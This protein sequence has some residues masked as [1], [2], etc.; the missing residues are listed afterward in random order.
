MAHEVHQILRESQ[1]I[2]LEAHSDHH[3]VGVAKKHNNNDFAST[4]AA[5]LSLPHTI[6]S[7]LLTLLQGSAPSYRSQITQGGRSTLQRVLVSSLVRGVLS[8]DPHATN[9][10]TPFGRDADR[11]SQLLGSSM[12]LSKNTE[13]A[14]SSLL[15]KKGADGGGM[16]RNAEESVAGAKMERG[17]PFMRFEC[18]L[19]IRD[20]WRPLS[21]GQYGDMDHYLTQYRK[22]QRNV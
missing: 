15:Q 8:Q 20:G 2:L 19:G 18:P 12:K 5:A 9:Q 1:D 6:R 4:S 16:G 10:P 7:M 3:H 21:D 13:L 11:I 17:S 14:S 22:Y